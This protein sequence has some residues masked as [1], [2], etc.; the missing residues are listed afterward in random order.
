MT[1]NRR[2]LA[3]ALP[4][5][6]WFAAA[7]SAL[8]GAPVKP[9]TLAAT[10]ITDTTATLNGHV[11]ID[12][13]KTTY[14]YFQYGTTAQYGTQTTT[15]GP[16]N[17]T[18]KDVSTSLT[19]LAPSTTYHFRVAATNTD[20]TTFGDDVTFTTAAP[21]APAPV[22]NSITIVAA[23]TLLTFGKATTIS[24]QVS[25]PGNAG[26]QV[27]LEENP[28][29]FLA[30]FRPTAVTGTTNPTGG[31]SLAVAPLLNDH[32]RVT[33]KTSP[34]VTSAE[35]AINVRPAIT[36]KLSDST[37]KVGQRVRFKGVVLPAH[38]GKVVQIERRTGTGSF[39]TVARATLVA[40]TPVNGVPRS[41]YSKRI[42]IRRTATYR[43]RLVPGD[44]DHVTG[45]SAK[46]RARVHRGR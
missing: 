45:V 36:L 3:V 5:V 28:Y 26:I 11:F 21:G 27:T 19:G 15:A 42:R 6:V 30:G 18:D 38:D 9:T 37:P 1:F 35:T 20:G 24:G 25:G 22:Q 17:G 32:Y 4:L 13:S 31:F 8:A 33:A 29:P 44:G 7:P 34:P 16:V 41:K 10:S 14:Y 12:Q 23:P 40:T 39:R 46:R 2:L 43:V